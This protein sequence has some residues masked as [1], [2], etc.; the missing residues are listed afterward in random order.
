MRE[1]LTEKFERPDEIWNNK[2]ICWESTQTALRHNL[3]EMSSVCWTDEYGR[4]HR[5][6]DKPAI[7]SSTGSKRWYK[8][9]RL[10]RKGGKPAIIHS[11]G[12]LEWFENGIKI[13]YYERTSNRKV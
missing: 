3:N 6:K 4:F 5:G 7:I 9:G 10:H 12:H 1:L 11:D 8:N 2:E 13:H